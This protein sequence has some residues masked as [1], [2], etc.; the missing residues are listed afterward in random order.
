MSW[1][2][3][4]S[5]ENNVQCS[6]VKTPT[7]YIEPI[8]RSK[9]GLLM[10]AYPGQEWLAYLM[11]EK[12]VD[13]FFVE[14]ISVPPHAEASG[15][16]AEAVP[17]H[18]PEGCLGVIHSHHSMGAFHSGTDNDYV[19]RN[20][21]VSVTVAKDNQGN[22][23]YDAVSLMTT[24]CG[25]LTLGKSIVK[26]VQL[27]PLFDTETFLKES[28]ANIDKGKLEFSF[29]KAPGVILQTRKPYVPI[30]YRFP[31]GDEEGIVLTGEDYRQIFKEADKGV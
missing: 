3:K 17:F 5:E 18:Q 15:G 12:K 10:E 20:F 4:N 1:K 7:I 25:K 2:V 14:D 24:P 26:Y 9:I 16:S 8:P 28:K 29:C 27:A 30:R 11:G 22:L 31:F 6:L 19:D 23:S 21:P 13:D